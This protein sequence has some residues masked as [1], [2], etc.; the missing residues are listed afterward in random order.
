MSAT[1]MSVNYTGV[2]PS[3]SDFSLSNSTQCIFQLGSDCMFR[4]MGEG[5]W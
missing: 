4:V 1:C 5:F 3:I 2:N